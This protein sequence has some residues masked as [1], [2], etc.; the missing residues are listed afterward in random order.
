MKKGTVDNWKQEGC[1]K[2]KSA[3]GKEKRADSSIR[4]LYGI[5]IKQ[6]DRHECRHWGRSFLNKR[7]A[8]LSK[9]FSQ[10]RVDRQEKQQ[11]LETLGLSNICVE[12][13]KA[14]WRKF[15]KRKGALTCSNWPA[16][17]NTI[18]PDTVEN[19]QEPWR[20]VSQCG[21]DRGLPAFRKPVPE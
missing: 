21:G 2:G 18:W 20:E 6:L 1:W 5:I 19:R 4:H 3:G 11:G 7:L 17:W 12:S 15:S 14:K 16:K 10:S 13:L 8:S 9:E